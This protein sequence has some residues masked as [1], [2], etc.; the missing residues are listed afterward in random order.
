MFEMIKTKNLLLSDSVSM[1][2]HS[3]RVSDESTKGSAILYI[4]GK[5]IR[6][7]NV[8]WE[9]D[10]SCNNLQ[11]VNI[12]T[13][14]VDKKKALIQ[15]PKFYPSFL[16]NEMKT[17]QASTLDTSVINIVPEYYNQHNKKRE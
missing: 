13:I 8:S 11:I 5:E 4:Y 14:V 3:C 7:V 10:D 9:Y 12:D 2:A 6:S 17:F 16:E 15:I 1:Q